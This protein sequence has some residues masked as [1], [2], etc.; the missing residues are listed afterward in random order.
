MP[1]S[2]PG[3]E[4]VPGVMTRIDAALPPGAWRACLRY[5]AIIEI[6]PF[7]DGNGRLARYVLNRT[8]ESAGR[9]PSLRPDN[10]ELGL[11]RSIQLARRHG[12][13]R[14]IAEQAAKGAHYGADLDRQWS[15]R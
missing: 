13:L 15:G 14:G 10:D 6:H 7:R 9:F 12:D 2:R 3:S 5:C 8:L 11:A 1:S 4:S